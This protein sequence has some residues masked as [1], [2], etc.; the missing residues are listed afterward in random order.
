M[1]IS[2]TIKKCHIPNM[3]DVRVRQGNNIELLKYWSLI[4]FLLFLQVLGNVN[5]VDDVASLIQQP[6]H[7]ETTLKQVF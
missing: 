6:W 1:V 2:V 5:V 7:T 3:V 4:L